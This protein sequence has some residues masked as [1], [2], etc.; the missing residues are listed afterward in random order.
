MLAARKALFIQHASDVGRSSSFYDN[1]KRDVLD[2]NRQ[3]RRE[4]KLVENKAFRHMPTPIKKQHSL[5]LPWQDWE[6]M[7]EQQATVNRLDGPVA[8]VKLPISEEHGTVAVASTPTTTSTNGRCAVPLH[9]RRS[10]ASPPSLKSQ[11]YTPSWPTPG[12]NSLHLTGH[13]RK[14]SL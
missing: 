12:S 14:L 8:A 10:P 4:G 9:G 13:L 2:D 5:R 11:G 7:K 6:Y 1:L 3:R